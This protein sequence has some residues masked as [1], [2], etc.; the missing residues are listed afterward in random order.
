[1]K[2]RQICRPIVT[3]TPGS[4][5]GCAA[6][7]NLANIDASNVAPYSAEWREVIGVGEAIALSS[8][9]A[10]DTDLSLDSVTTGEDQSKA[11]QE[12]LDLALNGPIQVIWDVQVTCQGLIVHPNTTIRVIKGCGAKLADN[13][14]QPILQNAKCKAL[15]DQ[16]DGFDSP[17]WDAIT[18][19]SDI[20][21]VGGIWHG[22]AINQEHDTE[23]DGWIVPLRFFNVT[24][25]QFAPDVIY[26]PRT[27]ACYFSNITHSRIDVGIIDVGTSEGFNYDGVH[28][29]GPASFLSIRIGEVK[30]MDDALGL[31]AD[32]LW[33]QT[34]GSTRGVLQPFAAGGDMT[35]I[36]VD[37]MVMRESGLEG[38]R[39]LSGASRMDRITIRNVSGSNSAPHIKLDNYSENPS[40]VH[41]DGP[42]NFGQ[43]VLDGWDVISTGYNSG[44]IPYGDGVFISANVE[45]LIIRNSTFTRADNEGRSPI[46][47]HKSADSGAAGDVG[48]LRLENVVFNYETVETLSYREVI[49]VSGEANVDVI[50]ALNCKRFARSP[51]PYISHVL[52]RAEDTATVGKVFV[53]G[54]R[55]NELVGYSGSAL[56]SSVG[57]VEAN[58][59]DVSFFQRGNQVSLRE[60]T[61]T[62]PNKYKIS[63]PDQLAEAFGPPDEAL[64]NC[65]FKVTLSTSSW[66]DSM[67]A[68]VGIRVPVYGYNTTTSRTGYFVQAIAGSFALVKIISGSLTSLANVA[69]GPSGLGKYDMEISAVGTDIKS[70]VKSQDSEMFLNNSGTWQ[71]ERTPFASVTDGSISEAGYCLVQRYIPDTGGRDLFL[72]NPVFSPI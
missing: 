51:D 39:L 66:S 1:M 69:V 56:N 12:I 13:S 2:Y 29:V 15:A 53:N 3:G 23:E 48:L 61:R 52:V 37:S 60:V 28:V 19:D 47:V 6:D 44:S 33:Y 41:F 31:N 57:S 65:S 22:N 7:D 20:A 30:A 46:R 10:S 59:S 58:S 49:R 26:M 18:K 21:L 5:G 50:E 34:G 17:D 42:G 25:L 11:I 9:C 38:I 72:E 63:K 43:I 62:A 24:R 70:Y 64:D 8:T 54:F 27:F 55:G 36:V 35:D 71:S 67:S 16:E 45:S 40:H 68:Y 14:N 32:D 4:A